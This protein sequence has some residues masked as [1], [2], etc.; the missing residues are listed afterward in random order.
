[1]KCEQWKID[2]ERWEL[3]GAEHIVTNMH[4]RYCQWL[5]PE[6]RERENEREISGQRQQ[7]HK[8][9]S[10]WWIESKQGDSLPTMSLP[11]LFSRHISSSMQLYICQS[12]TLLWFQFW[13]GL[14]CSFRTV[15]RAENAV[16]TLFAHHL[17]SSENST[18]PNSPHTA[19]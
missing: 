14:V 17:R 6:L 5:S 13:F 10:N 12:P 15:L 4:V 19:P 7:Q 2:T 3:Y 8:T 9:K 18:L 11:P 16:Y 1:M